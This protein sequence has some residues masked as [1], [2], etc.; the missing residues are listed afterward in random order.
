MDKRDIVRTFQGT[1]A[2][3]LDR[4]SASLADLFARNCGVDRSALSQ[5]LDHGATRLPRAE[6]L[7]AIASAETVSVDWLLG[8]SQN[9]T[10]I[11]EVARTE[12]I[13]VLER[14]GR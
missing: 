12:S 9:E 14:Q 3:L 8:L 6:T 7:C 4:R 1:A 13:E 10:T 11:A 5:F 2:I